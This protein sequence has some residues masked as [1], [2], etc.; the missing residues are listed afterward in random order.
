MM[1][2]KQQTDLDALKAQGKN[3]A[4]LEFAPKASAGGSPWKKYGGK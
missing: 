1:V 2:R 4:G 3:T